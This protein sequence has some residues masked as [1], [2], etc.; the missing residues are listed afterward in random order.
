MGVRHSASVVVF[1]A[2][3]HPR[4]IIC[5]QLSP[6]LRHLRSAGEHLGVV[7][8]GEDLEYSGQH[9]KRK[10]ETVVR[11]RKHISV[12][13]LVNGSFFSNGSTYCRTKL[14]CWLVQRLSRSPS[15]LVR[16]ECV[17]FL[18]YCLICERK[19]SS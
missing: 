19:K 8:T 9:R 15:I 4:H 16:S 10:R 11:T 6:S 5:E 18:K 1:C 2:Q 14:S 13:R 7:D 3:L 12:G 17:L